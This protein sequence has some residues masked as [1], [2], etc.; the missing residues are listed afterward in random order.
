MKYKMCTS[1]NEVFQHSYTIYCLDI[2]DLSSHEILLSGKM[3]IF[4]NKHFASS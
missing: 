4:L 2:V 1:K 3:Q